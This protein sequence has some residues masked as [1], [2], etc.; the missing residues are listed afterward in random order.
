MQLKFC[1]LEQWLQR[2]DRLIPCDVPPYQV[3]DPGGNAVRI[4][5]FLAEFRDLILVGGDWIPV[6]NDGTA[7]LEQMVHTPSL[8]VPKAKNLRMT[9]AGVEAN[10]GT[11]QKF[12]GAALLVGGAPNLYHWLIDNVPRLLFAQKFVDLRELR[13]VVNHPLLRFQRESLALL[14]FEEPQI[15]SAPDADALRFERTVVPSYLAA[16]TV[17]HP[18]VPRLLQSAFP[19]RRRSSC[20]RVYISRQDARNRRLLNEPDLT[21]LLARFGFERF[22][23]GEMSFQEQIDLCYGAQ[24]LVGVH[25]AAMANIAFCPAEATIFEIFSPHHQVSSMFMLSRTFKRNHVFVPARSVTFG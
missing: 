16:T 7:L 13:I 14:G 3:R 4:T 2:A 22:V 11:V 24:A 1:T 19:R 23:P 20:Q 10:L 8:F 12:P 25:G 17:V 5:P 9:D 6:L 21:R 15:L 18:V